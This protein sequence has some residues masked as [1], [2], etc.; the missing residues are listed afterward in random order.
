MKG[1]MTRGLWTEVGAG[2]RLQTEWWKGWLRAYDA[3]WLWDGN[4]T[5]PAIGVPLIVIWMLLM[6]L[7]CLMVWRSWSISLRPSQGS[8]VRL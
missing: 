1:W 8:L 3:K 2:D 6:P 5:G 7:N 4:G